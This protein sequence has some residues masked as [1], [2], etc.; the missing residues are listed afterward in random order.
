M[1]KPQD[2]KEAVKWW[3]LSAEQR[4]EQAQVNLVAMQDDDLDYLISSN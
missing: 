1:K 2:D 3:R 4:E